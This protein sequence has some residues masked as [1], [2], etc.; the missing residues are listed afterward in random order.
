VLFR[1]GLAAQSLPHHVLYVFGLRSVGKTSLL[2]EFAL[3]RAMSD[4]SSI[5]LDGRDIDLSPYA[6][7][8]RA[9]RGGPSPRD[10]SL[11]GWAQ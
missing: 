10:D 7:R 2:C 11:D 8:S 9:Q 6:L 1:D 3:L 5:Q 4:A